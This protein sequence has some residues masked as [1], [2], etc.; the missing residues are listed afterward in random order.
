M[1]S[2]IDTSTLISLAKVNYLEVIPKLKMDVAMP[3]EVYEEAVINGEKRGI[4]DST[5]IKTF[6]NNHEL[7][8]L[9]VKSD[10]IKA[11]RKKVGKGL[12]KGDEAVLS[13]AIREKAE[14]IIT[15]DDG[16]GKI[17]MAL[18]FNVMATP[19]LLMKGLKNK[20]LSFKEFEVLM[21]GLVI[22]N[23]LSSV[24]SELY[25]MEGKKYAEG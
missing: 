13:L 12:T 16:L 19:D 11:L 2:V 5:V 1:G 8:I 21:R 15:N 20:L 18:G 6:I 10:F 14:T 3:E 24:V 17:A 22:E 9:N 25:L 4:A 7:K 23:R